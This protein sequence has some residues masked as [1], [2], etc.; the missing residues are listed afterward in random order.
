MPL[1]KLG[2]CFS[3]ELV[4]SSMI[5]WPYCKLINGIVT[6]YVS[7]ILMHSRGEINSRPGLISIFGLS[8]ISKLFL[9]EEVTLSRYGYL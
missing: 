2:T 6:I 5:L 1:F 4:G 7:A 8:L 9:S 3:I